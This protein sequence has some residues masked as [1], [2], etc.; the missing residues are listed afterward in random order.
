MSQKRDAITGRKSKSNILNRTKVSKYEL[1]EY[2]M[3]DDED[4]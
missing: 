2:M 4:E 1:E 3:D